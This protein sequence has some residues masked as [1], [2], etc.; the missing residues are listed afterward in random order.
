MLSLGVFTAVVVVAS[1]VTAG[2]AGATPN[3]AHAATGGMPVYVEGHPVGLSLPNDADTFDMVR[4]APGAYDA[5][6][7]V[8]HD[9]ESGYGYFKRAA[10]ATSFTGGVI[11]GTTE[12]L[13]NQE[14][15]AATIT[16]SPN[17]HEVYAAVQQS[18]GG[19]SGGIYVLTKT[20]AAANFPALTASDLTATDSDCDNPLR[21]EGIAA[22]SRGRVAVL[23]LNNV[24]GLRLLIGTPG[25]RFS[26]IDLGAQIDDDSARAFITRDPDTGEVVIAMEGERNTSP[27]WSGAL[28]WT[29]RTDNTLHG[30][31]LLHTD[32]PSGESEDLAAGLTAADG[33]VWFGVE[34]RHVG[35][36][37]TRRGSSAGG[38]GPG[39]YVIHRDAKRHWS[40][41]YEPSAATSLIG[42]AAVPGTGVLH[43]L[44]IDGFANTTVIHLKRDAGGNWSKPTKLPKHHDALDVVSTNSGG[45]RYAYV[46]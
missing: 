32:M 28:A 18:C 34:R 20:A 16:R 36:I 37:V 27:R 10:G 2:T 12:P 15:P 8:Q 23:T 5:I 33:Q 24:P 30:P 6:G 42:L 38:D 4:T 45:Y 39:V 21:L 22:L 44:G 3:A 29:Y 11:G 7:V 26:T 46:K 19:A 41:P 31:I 14:E 43:L 13:D 35:D 1:S 40:A 9:G 25:G 17:G